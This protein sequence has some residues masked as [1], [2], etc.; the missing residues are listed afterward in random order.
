MNGVT[1]ISEMTSLAIHSMALIAA[2]SHEIIN[3]KSIAA[4]IGASEAHLS[5][6]LQRLVKGGLV[7]ST[8]GPNGGFVL[9]RPVGEISLLDIYQAIEGPITTGSCPL[10]HKACT[11]NR[12]L[13]GGML[14]KLNLEFE[15]Y[16][17]NRT[18]ADFA[19]CLKK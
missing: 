4:R 9:T 14:E 7:H 8:R 18:L 12:C 11:F 5:K 1:H 19:S 15:T 3:V 16:L 2:S 6:A 10:H 13:F 17:A